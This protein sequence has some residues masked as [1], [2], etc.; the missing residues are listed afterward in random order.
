MHLETLEKTKTLVMF[1]LKDLGLEK[2]W[3]TSGLKT[4]L[5]DT[6][7]GEIWKFLWVLLEEEGRRVQRYTNT[8]KSF[9]M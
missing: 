6:F 3:A 5:S 4:N 9:G 7:I 2:T 8:C 1:W